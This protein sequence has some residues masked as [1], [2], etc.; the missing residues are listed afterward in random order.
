MPNSE[1]QV[2]SGHC[3]W[4]SKEGKK[5]AYV[6]CRRSED[7]ADAVAKIAFE[8]VFRVLLHRTPR[9]SERK[10]GRDVR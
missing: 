4:S 10:R 7:N 2:H 1:D 9:K 6:Q 3:E 5:E 8:E